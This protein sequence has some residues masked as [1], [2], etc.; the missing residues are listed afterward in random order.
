[1]KSFKDFISEETLNELQLNIKGLGIVQDKNGREWYPIEMKYQPADVKSGLVGTFEKAA[2]KKG[3]V[4]ASNTIPMNPR[5]REGFSAKALGITLT[6]GPA[7]GPFAQVLIS[8]NDA[9]NES[10][11][12]K[13]LERLATISKLKNPFIRIAKNLQK[14]LKASFKV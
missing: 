10:A 2:R 13:K 8:V 3:Y 11:A 6:F 4:V 9:K 5:D 1:M 12:I 7:P 14:F